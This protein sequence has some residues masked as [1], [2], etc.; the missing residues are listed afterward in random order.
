MP[1]QH[2]AQTHSGSHANVGMNRAWKRRLI[3]IGPNRF[4]R[5]EDLHVAHAEKQLLEN[6]VQHPIE[7][8]VSITRS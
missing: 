3:L 7:N 5:R 1:Q 6:I 4:E 2:K 8:V